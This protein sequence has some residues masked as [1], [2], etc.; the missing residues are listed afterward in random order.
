MRYVHYV[1]MLIFGGAVLS[2]CATTP[3]PIYV[4][5]NAYQAYDCHQLMLEYQRVNSYLVHGSGTTGI[6]TTGVGVNVTAGR[7]GIYPSISFGLGRGSETQRTQI[8]RLLGER[9]AVI[10]AAKF[11]SCNFAANLTTTTTQ[12]HKK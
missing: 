9:D 4:S 8:S 5:P 6:T 10:Q 12:Q 1:A 7:G 2:G 3:K 11:K